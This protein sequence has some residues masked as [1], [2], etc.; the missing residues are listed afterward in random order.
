MQMKTFL[1]R[2]SI[3]ALFM[4]GSFAVTSVPV[5]A[6]R[7]EDCRERIDHAQNRLDRAIDRF[8]RHSDAAREA[9]HD[10]E[11]TRDWCWSHNR[12]RWDRDWRDGG[13]HHDRGWH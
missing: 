5:Q 6:Q 12:D 9:R 2:A 4:L 3:A 10:L 11:R 8:G 7:W 1:G 13:R